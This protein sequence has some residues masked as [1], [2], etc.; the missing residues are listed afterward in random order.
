MC[1]VTFIPTNQGCIITSNR[2]EKISREKA[3]SPQEYE[4]DG[5][6]ITFPKDPKAGGTWIAHT[7]NKIV[8]LLNGAKEKHL[9]K[10]FY[11]KS[12][13]LIVLEIAS[14]NDS[15][16]C[17]KNIDLT[18]IE[19]FTMVLFE[20]NKLYQL[21]WNEIEKS[22]EELSNTEH[23]IWSSS[24]LYSREI[25][26]ERAI[27]FADFSLKNENPSANDILNFHQFTKSENKEF[28]LQINRNN[29][30]K[31]ISITQCI[32]FNSKIEMVYLDLYN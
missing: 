30:L 21:Q 2:D 18:E 15:L 16:E 3:I 26:T 5:K 17:W 19:P 1:T 8:V 27:W 11:R 14:E 10:S 12:R 32:V 25:R 24:T 7:N 9:V 23:H 13:G 22:I 4:I 31:T 20:N 6:K 29:K 28:G